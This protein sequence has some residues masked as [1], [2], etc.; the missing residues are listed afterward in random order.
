MFPLVP[1]WRAIPPAS[2]SRAVNSGRKK[3]LQPDNPLEHP[4]WDAHLTRRPDFS[5]FHGAAWAK[6]LAETYGFKP[7]WQS[8]GKSL[9]PLME[10]NSWLTGRRG[11]ALPFTDEC[12]PLCE[13]AAE[14]RPLFQKAVKLGQARRWK[15]IELRGGR[16]FF[17]EAPASLGFY[18]HRL[19]LAPEVA[20]M[21][22]DM[23]GSARQAVRKAEKDGVTVEVSQS[24]AATRDFYDLQCLTRKRHGLPPQ[25]LSF[26]LNIQRHVLSQNQGM[27]ALAGWRGTKIAG[28][29]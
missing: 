8:D 23:D 20:R 3:L 27:V 1:R 2:S 10:V 7:V 19:N 9:L 11:I 25:P 6:V 15:S 21:F 29:V 16:E 13:S 24:E 17:G 18:G 26:F 12:P 14:F 5:F 4:D 22:D 28:A